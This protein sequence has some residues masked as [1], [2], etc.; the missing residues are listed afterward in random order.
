MATRAGRKEEANKTSTC[1]SRC[2]GCLACCWE[3]CKLIYGEDLHSEFSDTEAL[4]GDLEIAESEQVENTDADLEDDLKDMPCDLP[5]PQSANFSG[6]H[7][8]VT[9]VEIHVPVEAEIVSGHVHDAQ[10]EPLQL[11]PPTAQDH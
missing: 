3:Y 7:E 6:E 10:E 8:D 11:I 2:I 4:S 1:C 5:R 9:T